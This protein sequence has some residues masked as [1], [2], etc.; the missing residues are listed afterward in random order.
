MSSGLETGDDFCLFLLL[1]DVPHPSV[2]VLK[3]FRRVAKYQQL[4]QFNPTVIKGPC[5]VGFF[6]D[7]DSRPP[8]FQFLFA[9]SSRFVYASYR[10]ASSIMVL[11][12]SVVG[13]AHYHFIG[14]RLFFQI[15]FFMITGMFLKLFR[16]FSFP[17]RIVAPIIC[18]TF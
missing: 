2:K 15:P 17:I 8:K 3:S 5:I 12:L 7:V 1:T 4:G 6:P 18:L 13:S 11:W 14:E 16:N 10:G 9:K